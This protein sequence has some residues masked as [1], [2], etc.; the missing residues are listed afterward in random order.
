[1]FEAISPSISLRFDAMCWSAAERASGAVR[2]EQTPSL[3]PFPQR[4]PVRFVV[5]SSDTWLG[6]AAP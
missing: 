5:V 4:I 6:P 2:T 1:M 3:A